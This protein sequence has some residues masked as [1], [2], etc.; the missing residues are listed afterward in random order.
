[1]A[2]VQ[3]EAV[4]IM[5]QMGIARVETLKV[6]PQIGPHQSMATEYFLFCHLL[7]VQVQN[8][9]VNRAFIKFWHGRRWKQ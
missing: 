1:M 8:G 5:M 6:A 4:I 7:C 9:A 3:V 2:C